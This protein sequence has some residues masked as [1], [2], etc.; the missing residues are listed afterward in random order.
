MTE[1]SIRLNVNG[2]PCELRVNPWERLV[3]VL[4][5]KLGL[6]GTKIGCGEGECG[7]CTVILDGKA[8]LSC[9]LLAVQADGR[10]IRTIEGID[11]EGR[12]HPLQEA[13]VQDAA[14]QCG[15]C[16]PG[17]ITA[18][19]ALLEGDPDPSEEAVRKAISSNLC[20]CSG[21]ERQVRAILDAARV[22]RE[23]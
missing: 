16:T 19:T 22:M 8:A 4:R 13:F 20:R 21:Y 3:D 1:V 9:L 11:R 12:L 18:A 15:F 6:T 7:A 10:E 5:D 14:I 17:M 2:E 23:E